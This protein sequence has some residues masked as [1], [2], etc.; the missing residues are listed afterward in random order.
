M[1][2]GMVW[3]PRSCPLKPACNVGEAMG[4]RGS[5]LWGGD[6][7]QRTAVRA[8]WGH[9]CCWRSRGFPL[10]PHSAVLLYPRARHS[11]LVTVMNVCY[12]N[13]IM[14]CFGLDSNRNHRSS[15]LMQMD[16]ERGPDCL[17][18]NQCVPLMLAKLDVE[19][20]R[21]HLLLGRGRK[22]PSSPGKA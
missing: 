22:L 11:Q 7:W 21:T 6:P 18:S 3:S 5:S 12:P 16:F 2:V 14:C 8:G 15:L 17:R 1:A 9:P 13:L 4:P 20:S 10:P 19:V